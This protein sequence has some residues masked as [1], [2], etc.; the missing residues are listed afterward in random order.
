MPESLELRQVFGAA[1]VT[2]PLL[3]DDRL[4]PELDDV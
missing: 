3:D 2:R 4:D 1:Y